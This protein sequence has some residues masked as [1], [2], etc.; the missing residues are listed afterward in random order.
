MKATL[1]VINGTYNT[2]LAG[3]G[4]QTLINDIHDYLGLMYV[5]VGLI[6]TLVSIF[7]SV[8]SYR[9]AN[10]KEDKEKAK[11]N[12]KDGVKTVIETGKDVIEDL[13]DDGKLNGSNK[14]QE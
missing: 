2:I 11:E 10:S 9:K 1:N 6:G 7:I 8:A 4:L 3:T 14:K 5:I 13:S 12:I